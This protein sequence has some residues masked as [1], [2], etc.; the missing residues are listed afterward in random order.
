M[1]LQAYEYNIKHKPGKQL[2]NTA[3]SRLPLSQQPQ[4][5]PV[6]GSINLVHQQLNTT[7][8]TATEIKTWTDKDPLLSKVRRFVMSGW[9]VD[10]DTSEEGLR[11]YLNR[12]DDTVDV[13]C[14]GHV[15]L[16]HQRVVR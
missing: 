10:D 12:K 8:V 16:F 3:L 9:P 7:P 13:S 15:L 4:T 5:V 1:T 14:G 6:P 11:P 2:A